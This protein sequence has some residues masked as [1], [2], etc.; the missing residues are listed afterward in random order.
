MGL[1][2][3]GKQSFK[4]VLRVVAAEGLQSLAGA[5][6][7]CADRVAQRIVQIEEDGADR[8]PR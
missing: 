3:S 2:D 7:S 1:Q 8:W 4:V 5:L 6:R